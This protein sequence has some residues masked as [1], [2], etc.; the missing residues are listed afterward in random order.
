MDWMSLPRDSA[1]LLELLRH[2]WP[3]CL[4]A[5]A[6]GLVDSI[7]GGGGLITV[8]TLLNIGVPSQVLLGTNKCLST[9][10]SLPAV[11]R[12]GRAGLLPRLRLSHYALL[13]VVSALAA[14]L[15][16]FIS[17]Q[18]FLLSQLPFLVPLLLLFVML[19]ML[20]RWFWDERREHRRHLS[21]A[22]DR[23][24]SEQRLTQQ[25]QKPF[26]LFT[27]WAIAAYDGLF[28]PG[29]G[30]FFLN[31]FESMGLPTISANAI[32]K[33]FNLASNLGALL[34]FASQGRWLPLVGIIA[35]GFYLTGNY[36]GAGLVLKRGQALV[37][38][39]V[40]LATSGLL[41]RHLVRLMY[42]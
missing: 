39:I 25:L 15:G 1:A 20:K 21:G 18:A 2:I 23:N 31:L 41:L 3:L 28:G 12:Y 35:A 8:P 22:L 37:R 19:F 30:T 26:R 14:A 36:L 42:E 40:L 17:Q 13:T 7:G 9:L 29:T 4:A 6:A 33:I 34:W 11:Y 32:T 16:A 10:G 5:L 38:T 27:L 24:Q